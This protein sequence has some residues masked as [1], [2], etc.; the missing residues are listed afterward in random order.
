[1]QRLYAMDI[2]IRRNHYAKEATKRVLSLYH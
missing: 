2:S 1:M